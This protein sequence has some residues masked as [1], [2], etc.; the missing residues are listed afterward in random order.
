MNKTLKNNKH[1]TDGLSLT[2]YPYMSPKA[3][4]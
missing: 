3:V 4:R 2:L 1:F